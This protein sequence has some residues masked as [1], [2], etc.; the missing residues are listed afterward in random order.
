M[1]L[2]NNVTYIAIYRFFIQILFFSLYESLRCSIYRIFCDI[3]VLDV[4][5][6]MGLVDEL[7]VLDLHDVVLLQ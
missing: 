1:L 5:Q 7:L 4:L 3:S 6:I 2:T